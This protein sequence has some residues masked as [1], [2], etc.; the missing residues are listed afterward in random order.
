MLL[1]FISIFFIYS[2]RD[3]ALYTYLLIISS[4]QEDLKCSLFIEKCELKGKLDFVAWPAWLA[5]KKNIETFKNAMPSQKKTEG[6]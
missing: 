3:I 1:T 4:L 6:N 2:C 5:Q